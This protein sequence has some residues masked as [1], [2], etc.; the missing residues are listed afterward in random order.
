MPTF[1][2]HPDRRTALAAGAGLLAATRLV[3][4]P[5]DAKPPLVEGYTN[6][7]SF[8]PGEELTLHV[9]SA[10]PVFDVETG[11]RVAPGVRG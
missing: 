8:T 5:K 3:A 7:V 9:S 6:Q 10:S 11:L 4:Q 1:R 2:Q